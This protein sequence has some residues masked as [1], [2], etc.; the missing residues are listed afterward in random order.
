M[1]NLGTGSAKSRVP[2]RKRCIW[3]G[4]LVRRREGSGMRKRLARRI[5]LFCNA[6]QKKIVPVLIRL[7]IIEFGEP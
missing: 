7:V 1:C 6:Q 4:L 5:F 3:A 2:G